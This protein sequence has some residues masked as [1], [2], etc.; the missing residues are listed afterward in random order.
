[1]FNYHI[2]SHFSLLSIHTVSHT[3]PIKTL[4]VPMAIRLSLIMVN[5]PFMLIQD[6]LNTTV[7]LNK[8]STDT[9]ILLFNPILMQM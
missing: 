4:T 1:M 2:R 8:A 7:I 3:I 6:T 5:H 9:L